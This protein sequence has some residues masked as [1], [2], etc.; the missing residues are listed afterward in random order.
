MYCRITAM[1]APPQ[2]PAKE[3]GD[4]SDLPHNMRRMLG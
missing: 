2:L 3:L 4:H 1:G